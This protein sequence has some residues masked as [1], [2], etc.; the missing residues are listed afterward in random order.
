MF[1]ST[2]SAENRIRW[3][4]RRGFK[5]DSEAGGVVRRLLAPLGNGR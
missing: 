3:R 4:D 2:G 5:T 1:V